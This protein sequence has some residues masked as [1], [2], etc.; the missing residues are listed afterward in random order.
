MQWCEG[1]QR[2]VDPSLAPYGGWVCPN[3]GNALDSP[4]G[5][6]DAEDGEEKPPAYQ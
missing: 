5:E 4:L 1:C 2:N 6:A 3:C